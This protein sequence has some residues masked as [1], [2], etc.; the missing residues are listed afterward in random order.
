MLFNLKNRFAPTD[1]A[2]EHEVV[3]GWLKAVRR[4]TQ[5][6]EVE[7]WLQDLETAY[8]KAVELHIPDVHRTRPHFA[9]TN[10]VL[11]LSSTFAE[12]WDIKLLRITD[13]D[14]STVLFK[15]MVREFRDLCRI[16]KA[17]TKPVH[18]RH[19]A[20][21]TSLQ[22]TEADGTPKVYK[23]ICGEE[24]RYAQCRYLIPSTRA[25]GWKPSPTIQKR[26]DD[27]M[28]K[29]PA[30]QKAQIKKAQ[31]HAEQTQLT[32]TG[33]S[34]PRSP[35]STETPAQPPPPTVLMAHTQPGLYRVSDTLAY[36]QYDLHQSVILDSG[37]SCHVGNTRS[38]FNSFTPATNSEVLY[39]GDNVIPI[40]GHGTYRVI[41]QLDGH[42]HS[43]ELANTAYVPSFHC[44]VAS[45]RIFNTKGVFWENKTNR[46]IYGDHDYPFAD[47]PMV[48]DQW[49]LEYNKVSLPPPTAFTATQHAAFKAHSSRHPR[50]VN[51]ATMDQWHEMMGHLYPEALAHLKEHCQG[52]RITTSELTEH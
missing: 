42:S 37:A 29:I 36:P 39:A 28:A 21:P 47:T 32:G 8:D 45:L 49:V 7:K 52:V 2:R 5:G 34:T 40:E 16:N 20:F 46:L 50:P 31:D 30:W 14:A 38:K 11:D 24:H 26:V 19:G 44:S 15:D 3:N 23:C 51:A 4:P 35:G 18:G 13:D 1:W 48:Y 43:I 10:A 9:F 33:S 12:S 25:A 22:G 6:V 17:R 27:A 41:I